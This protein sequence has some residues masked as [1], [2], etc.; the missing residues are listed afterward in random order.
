M[1]PLDTVKSLLG[2]ADDSQDGVLRYV[3]DSVEESICNYCNLD[4][5][6]SGLFN[7]AFRMAVDM[8]RQ[9]G[10]GSLGTPQ[11]P[12]A[13]ISE[14][15]TSVSFKDSTATKAYD[16]YATSVLKNYTMQLNRYRRMRSPCPCCHP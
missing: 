11:G 10:F 8:Y 2:I 5:V 4:Q 16:A 1:L 14:G 7:T 9:E 15:D 3:M 13:S 6:P 12:V